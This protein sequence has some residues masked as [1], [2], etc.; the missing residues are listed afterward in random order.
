MSD[1]DAGQGVVEA[2]YASPAALPSPRTRR[3]RR[4]PHP[5]RGSNRGARRADVRHQ[6]DLCNPEDE[7]ATAERAA[8]FSWIT[9]AICLLALFLVNGTVL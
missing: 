6:A 7:V 3:V 1:A 2:F 5:H 4:E 9:V 8:R